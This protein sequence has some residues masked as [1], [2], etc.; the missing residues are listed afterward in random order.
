ML[1]EFEETQEVMEQETRKEA[2]SIVAQVKNYVY[3]NASFSTVSNWDVRLVF[4]E[5]LP[6]GVT[7]PRAA[8]VMPHQQAKAFSQMLSRQIERLE[9]TMGEIR[10]LPKKPAVQPKEESH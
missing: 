3:V 4:G 7:E 10:W 2:D 5:R 1:P 8:I 9:E 6:S